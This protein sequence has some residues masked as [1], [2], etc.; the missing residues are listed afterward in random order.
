MRVDRQFAQ[1]LEPA[2]PDLRSRSHQIGLA[3]SKFVPARQLNLVSLT[4]ALTAKAAGDAVGGLDRTT[5]SELEETLMRKI[6]SATMA[7]TALLGAGVTQAGSAPANL[8]VSVTVTANCVVSNGTLPMAYVPGNGNVKANTTMSVSCSPGANPTTVGFGWGL[9]G[10]AVNQTRAAANGAVQVAYNLY[11]TN[12]YGTVLG[13]TVGTNTLTVTLPATFAAPS[14]LTIYG[15]VPDTAANQLVAAGTY[16][17]TVLATL[18][19]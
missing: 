8:T 14:T 1:E 11:T 7:A 15:E 17:D 16:T 5:V 18:A 4:A 12:S 3:L 13:T 19:F 6:L 9:N 10:S 2:K